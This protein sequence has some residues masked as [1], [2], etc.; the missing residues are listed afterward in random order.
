MSK[1]IFKR[2]FTLLE[3]LIAMGLTAVL[4]TVLSSFYQQVAWIDAASDRTE[5]EQFAV[6]YLGARLARVLPATI[7][8]QTLGKDFVFFTSGDLSGLLGARAPSLLFVFQNGPSLDPERANHALGRLY[9]NRDKQLCLAIWS[10]PKNWKHNPPKSA[11]H[12]VL[13]ENVEELS[14]Q[15][16]IAPER[17]RSLVQKSLGKG[18][19]TFKEKERANP[20][21]NSDSKVKNPEEG[22]P[23]SEVE[24]LSN[25]SPEPKGEWV[26]EWKRE[27]E[28]LPAMMRIIVKRKIG[29]SVAETVYAFPLPNSPQLIVY[30]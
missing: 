25:N 4:L 12:E 17:D 27:Y 13:M 28:Q 30:E 19:K 2:A 20:S 9:L 22:A 1:R 15:F 14:F 29:D 5:K 11:Q 7:G 10:S 6:R 23:T 3:L 18:F 21:G 24:T 26:E 8:E 16:F